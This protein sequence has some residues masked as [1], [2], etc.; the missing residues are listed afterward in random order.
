MTKQTAEA[1]IRT[2]I[3]G[4]DQAAKEELKRLD[5]AID[6]AKDAMKRYQEEIGYAVAFREVTHLGDVAPNVHRVRQL[7]AAA[8]GASKR[9][10]N[11]LE[12]RPQE[13]IDAAS[14]YVERLREAREEAD[15]SMVDLL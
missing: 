10:S 11:I 14:E 8:R 2:S 13:V 1:A 12:E 4:I 7:L 3:Q 15:S 5:H 6:I 9:L